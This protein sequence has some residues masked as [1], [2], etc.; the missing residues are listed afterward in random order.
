MTSAIDGDLVVSGP[1]LDRRLAQHYE[2]T[3]NNLPNPSPEIIRF[4]LLPNSPQHISSMCSNIKS[5]KAS[6]FDH[7][8]EV[9]FKFCKR[10]AFDCHEFDCSSCS[11]KMGI[12][13]EMMSPNYWTEDQK[14]KHFCCRLIPLN[15][16]HPNL[17]TVDNYRPIIVSSCFVKFLE[18]A[19]LPELR[20]YQRNHLHKN[21]I[22]FVPGCSIDIGKQ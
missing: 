7:V 11:T 6:A 2:Q 17:P 4:P 5:N 1:E 20:E 3:H 15:K 8:H 22:G 18:G 21:Q 19:I 14:R 12:L 10:S 13:K 16:N 9:L